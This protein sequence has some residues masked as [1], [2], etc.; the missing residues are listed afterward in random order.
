MHVPITM[1]DVFGFNFPDLMIDCAKLFFSFF[2]NEISK[3]LD[4]HTIACIVPRIA[5]IIEICMTVISHGRCGKIN[6]RVS[7]KGV[8]AEVKSSRGTARII[9]ATKARYSAPT[10]IIE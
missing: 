3:L 10:N 7:G 8:S 4:P 2:T 6:R 1:R 9:E 5:E